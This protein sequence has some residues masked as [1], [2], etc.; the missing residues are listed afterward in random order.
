MKHKL[1]ECEKEDCYVCTGGLALCT[2]C[3]GGEGTLPQE[4]PGRMMTEEEE[5]DVMH[6]RTEFFRGRWWIAIEWK[7]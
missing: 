3:K 7:S 1:H 4:C 5:Q 2:V 6:A